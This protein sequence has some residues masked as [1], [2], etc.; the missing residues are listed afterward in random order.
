[1]NHYCEC[2]H[3]PSYHYGDT[4]HCEAVDVSLWGDSPCLCNSYQKDSDE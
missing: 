2:D 3:L 4:G 1:M